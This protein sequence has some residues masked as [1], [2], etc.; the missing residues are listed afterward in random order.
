MAKIG[1]KDGALKVGIIGAGFVANFHV[2]ALHSVRGVEVSAVYAL[3]GAEELRD[4]AI[5]S[6]VGRPVVCDSIKDLCQKA[7]VVCLFLPNF[8]RLEAVKAIVKAT[9]KGSTVRGLI[10]EKPLARNV[11]EANEILKLIESKGWPTAYFENQIH[12]PAVINARQQLKVI[13]KQMGPPNLVRTAEEHGGPHEA[14][15]WDPT[16]QGGG[17]WCDMGCHSVAVGEELATPL[18][19]KR[20]IPLS[21]TAN[22]G[23]LKWGN[24][25]WRSKLLKR[26]VDYTKT[27]AEDYACV[28]YTFESEGGKIAMVQATDSW[29]YEAPGLRLNM[30]MMGP[31]YAVNVNT[32]NSPSGIFIS[33]DAATSVGNAELAL[34]KSQAS[35]GQLVVQPNE[36][37]LYGYV[38]EW[39]D[40]VPALK[41]GKSGLLDLEY[42][43]RVVKLVMVA[44]MSHERAETIDLKRGAFLDSSELAAYVPLIQQGKGHKILAR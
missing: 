9:S 43:V 20:L 13:E 23:L 39:R 21:V 18:F 12:M 30:E 6:G 19:G 17:V 22:M 1:E 29:M 14:W 38:G 7:E 4:R 27:P 42:G 34:E 15:F 33:D 8:A 36:P 26:G 28:S 37:D 31:G 16:R 10:A 41:Q 32:L 24:E 5:A 11:A 25:P 40:A 44:Y 2:R 3:K 35:R